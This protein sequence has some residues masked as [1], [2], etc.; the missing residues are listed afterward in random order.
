MIDQ[1]P[2][3]MQMGASR[4]GSVCTDSIK[5]F[6]NSRVPVCVCNVCQWSARAQELETTKT[7]ARRSS[8][9]SGKNLFYRPTQNG[10]AFTRAVHN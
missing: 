8:S 5:H 3:E 7:A 1:R 4:V 6:Q 9:L 10:F 2:V